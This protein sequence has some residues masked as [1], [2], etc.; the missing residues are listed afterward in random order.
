VSG[1]FSLISV[2]GVIGMV[3]GIVLMTGAYVAMVVSIRDANRRLQALGFVYL[4]VFV[5][6]MS[7][8]VY[9]ISLLAGR[10]PA[11]VGIPVAV[12][13]VV[14]AAGVRLAGSRSFRESRAAG[15][16]AC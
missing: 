4:G 10:L 14:V 6:A 1:L 9:A 12:L 2:I 8:A 13:L 7:G 11:A 3:L 5:V 15:Q 16:A